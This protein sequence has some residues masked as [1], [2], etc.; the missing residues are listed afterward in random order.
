LEGPECRRAGHGQRRARER[1]APRRRRQRTW[2]A[3]SV[4]R[5]STPK[6]PAAPPAASPAADFP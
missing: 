6:F 2:R 1:L 3:R 5:C 4:G